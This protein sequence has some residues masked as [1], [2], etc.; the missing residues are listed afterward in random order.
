[1]EDL[2]LALRTYSTQVQFGAVAHR[3]FG[4]FLARTLAYF[5]D[6]E[7]ANA[8]GALAGKS[9]LET[10]GE[11]LAGIDLYARQS[12]RIARDF[13]GGWYSKHNW[14]SKGEIS[15]DE[16]SRFVGYAFAPLFR[17]LAEEED[18]LISVCG[19]RPRGGTGSAKVNPTLGWTAIGEGCIAAIACAP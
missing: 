16:A 14:Q 1:V 3:F 11:L 10:N 19:W 2:R 4:D 18:G 15:Q 7:V 8:V 6:R 5:L 13:A 9:A 17:V 12:A